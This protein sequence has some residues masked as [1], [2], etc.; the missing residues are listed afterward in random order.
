MRFSPHRRINLVHM[1]TQTII[2][3]ARSTRYIPVLWFALA[4][5]LCHATPDLGARGAGWVSR[6]GAQTAP[7]PQTTPVARG[8]DT[9]P[10]TDTLP[11]AG[12]SR[13]PLAPGAPV[14]SPA[15]SP[16]K[17]SLSLNPCWHAHEPPPASLNL[18]ALSALAIWCNCGQGQT[19]TGR[20]V[21]SWSARCA[22]MTASVAWCSGR[23]GQVHP[24]RGIRTPYPRSRALA[25]R[26]SRPPIEPSIAP[27]TLRTVQN[28]WEGDKS[29]TR[30][31]YYVNYW[32]LSA[33][34]SRHNIRY[35]GRGRPPPDVPVVPHR[36]PSCQE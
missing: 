26:L 6:P 13:L 7:P 29:A 28:V 16:P 22:T 27:A 9:N 1:Q 15:C 5:I 21:C 31:E 3:H 36:C 33:P 23:T 17:N 20:R 25:E 12:E 32:V 11:I 35:L 18:K 10:G 4:G 8:D 14:D 19:P 2:S 30:I 24:L 34:Y